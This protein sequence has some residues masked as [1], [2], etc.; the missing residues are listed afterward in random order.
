MAAAVRDADQH[1]GSVFAEAPI[2]MSLTSLTGTL[3]RVNR[4]LCEICGS[5]EAAGAGFHLGR[6]VPV[7]EPIPL[8]VA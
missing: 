3:I 2:G 1:M 6:V 7:E 5:S 4:K 8:W